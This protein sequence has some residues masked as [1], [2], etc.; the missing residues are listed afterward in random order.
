MILN[1]AG[2]MGGIDKK[3][4]FQRGRQDFI[5]IFGCFF[6]GKGI[7]TPDPVFKKLGNAM[8]EYAHLQDFMA[9]QLPVTAAGVME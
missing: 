2:R 6:C 5:K 8:A 9:V 1:E 4:P 3:I 7:I